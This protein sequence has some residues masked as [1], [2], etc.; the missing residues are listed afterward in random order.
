LWLLLTCSGPAV[1]GALCGSERTDERATVAYV[2][3]GDTLR[4]EDGRKVRVIGINTPELGKE[5][6][7]D[8]PFAKAARDA[9]RA[10]AGRGS[11]I[12]LRIGS[13]RHDRYGRLLA[14]VYLPEGGSLGAELLARGLA[15]TLVIPPN[16][17]NVKCF[18]R[19]EAQ[20]REQA[21]GI[22]NLPRYRP[23][24][25][26][27]LKKADGYRLV[28]GRV[29]RVGESRSSVWLNLEGSVALRIRRGDLDQFTTFEPRELKGRE[30]LAR[31]W[32]HRRHG[33]L[34]MTVR[35]PAA[36]EI[37]D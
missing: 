16:T 10:L 22:W 15:T 34:R 14:H 8:E 12:G 29:T 13:E 26:A 33:E 18:A 32:L 24:S 23:V 25:S 35:H 36:L 5:G 37:M 2:Y 17:R 7:P 4:L 19:V 21:K 20:A 27:S 6:T 11:R 9:T 28:R 3:D 1:A 30:V 31:G